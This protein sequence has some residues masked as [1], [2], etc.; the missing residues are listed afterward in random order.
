MLRLSKEFFDKFKWRN[1]L[2]D[3]ENVYTIRQN[4]QCVDFWMCLWATELQQRFS[5][6]Q[7]IKKIDT[8]DLSR[9]VIIKEGT[10]ELIRLAPTIQSILRYSSIQP[11]QP[12]FFILPIK[13]RIVF[14]LYL[15]IISFLV[16]ITFFVKHTRQN[17][18][19]I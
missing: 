16:T 10:L 13:S 15:F 11:Y 17:I 6:Q 1:E 9:P 19:W 7:I 2:L 4:A 3:G 8:V 12:L 18:M 5:D 14:V